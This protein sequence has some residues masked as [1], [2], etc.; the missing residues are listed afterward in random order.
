MD[1]QQIVQL[2]GHA[3]KQA[4]DIPEINDVTL[5]CIEGCWEITLTTQHHEDE[6]DQNPDGLRK[7]VITEEGVIETDLE[8]V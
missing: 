8:P 5:D 1:T 2:L 3:L 4:G 6:E 7:W